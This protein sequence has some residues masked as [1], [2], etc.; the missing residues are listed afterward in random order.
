M[1]LSNSWSPMMD[2]SVSL[3][4]SSSHKTK[5]FGRRFSRT[6]LEKSSS[7]TIVFKYIYIY[8]YIYIIQLLLVYFPLDTTYQLTITMDG[9]LMPKATER[10]CMIN[11]NNLFLNVVKKRQVIQKRN[12]V[13]LPHV[14]FGSIGF[15]QEQNFESSSSLIYSILMISSTQGPSTHTA[16][17]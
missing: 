13:A 6:E 4:E 11:M 16:L 10:K 8:I 14:Q 12:V 17:F 2:H 1:H 7:C 5:R 3:F 15:F 9:V